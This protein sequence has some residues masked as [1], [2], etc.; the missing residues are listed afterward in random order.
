[1]KSGS[2][3]TLAVLLPNLL[4]LIAPPLSVPQTPA[5]SRARAGIL[6]QAM[7][8]I[9][10][11]GA[12]VIPFFCEIDL[13]GSI[14]LLIGALAALVIYYAGWCRYMWKDREYRLLFSPLL[15]IPLPMAV[16]PVTYFALWSVLLNS[17]LLAA[18]TLILGIGHINVS[19]GE[20]LRSR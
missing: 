8:R 13:K 12:F 14:V 16:C 2:L 1:M 17:W 15:G 20:R 3:I 5:G 7:E 10:Q 18:A 19:I 4:F 9:G 6:I 11:V